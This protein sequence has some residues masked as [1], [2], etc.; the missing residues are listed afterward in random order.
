MY[1]DSDYIENRP[2]DNCDK[3]LVS[4]ITVTFNIIENGRSN[5]FR[6]CLESIKNQ[7][8]R[9]L[10]HIVIDGAS[11]DCT[12]E[13]ID[14][15]AELGWIKYTSEPDSGIYEAMNKGIMI[16]KG[17]YLVFLNSDDFF[18]DR[19][20]IEVSVNALENSNADFSYAP[21]NMLNIDGTKNRKHPHNYPKISNVFF[22]MPFCHQTMFL[23][24]SA[25]IKEGMFDTKFQSAGDYDLV[26]R[27]CLKNYKAIY[28]ERIF[29][30]YSMGGISITNNESSI[31]E[32]AELYYKNYK[33]LCSITKEECQLIY[34]SNNQNLPAKLAN[35]LNKISIFF[36][37]TEYIKTTC[38]KNKI[39]FGLALLSRWMRLG[40]K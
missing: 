1:T 11:T 25:L 9:N 34:C 26:L 3:P 8:Y 36:D 37:S 17:K 13:L 21:A 30:S 28:V 20:G 12:T 16:S 38:N 32:V 4:I 6:R 5:C 35:M 33:T 23:K 31:K 15:Y 39:L 10:E 27:L 18:H 40:G 2:R 22:L 14:E 24:K 29:V 7:T 19:S